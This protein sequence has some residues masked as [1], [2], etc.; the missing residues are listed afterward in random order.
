MLDV[1]ST[2]L[3]V[4][5]HTGY[6]AY[7]N[8]DSSY[9]HMLT[10]ISIRSVCW[11]GERILVGTN[12]GEVFE[13]SAADKDK[14]VTIVQVV[15]AVLTLRLGVKRKGAFNQYITDIILSNLTSSSCRFIFYKVLQKVL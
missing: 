15:L 13:V 9:F 12:G 3:I 4:C 1:G 14:P 5:G 6:F 11:G 8:L 10:G 2:K 7:C